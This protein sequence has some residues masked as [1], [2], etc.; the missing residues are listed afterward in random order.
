MSGLLESEK[1]TGERGTVR[2]ALA[3]IGFAVVALVVG[4]CVACTDDDKD[5][6]GPIQLVSHRYD[7]GGGYDDGGECWDEYDCR[8]REYGDG[9]S[10]RYDQNYGSRDDRN[11]NRNR[12]R[13][14]FSPG[15]FRDS[16]VDAFNNVCMPGATCNYDGRRDQRDRRGEPR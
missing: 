7:D 9:Y 12:D 13:G 4:T 10:Q 15:P 14:A 3:V 11:R 5:S 8:G 16:P 1:V 2:T 6:F